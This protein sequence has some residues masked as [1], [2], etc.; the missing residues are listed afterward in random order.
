MTAEFTKRTDAIGLMGLTGVG[1]IAAIGLLVAMRTL[2]VVREVNILAE[3][4]LTEECC[5]EQSVLDLERC[6]G[7]SI[8]TERSSRSSKISG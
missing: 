4:I 5:D 6:L 1:R 3:E 2:L 8:S 7:G